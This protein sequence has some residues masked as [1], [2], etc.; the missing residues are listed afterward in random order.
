M[1]DD[2]Q[3]E[4]R[5]L[6][7]SI[8]A[9][10]GVQKV[11]L[12]LRGGTLV[13]VLSGEMYETDVAI[14]DG[15]VV[16]LGEGYEGREVVDCSGKW[17]APGF[18]DGHMHVES[19]LVTV[20]EFA[21][22]ALSRGTVAAILDPHEI[23]NVHGIE[24][25]LYILES[26]KGIPLKAF[27]MASSCVPA[28]HME[29]A[30]AELSA[31]DLVPLFDEE[32]VIG[33]AEVMNFP[34]VVFGDE[35]VLAKVVAAQRDNVVID[36]HA[37]GLSGRDLN[38]YIAAGVGSDHECTTLEEAREKLRKGMHVMIREASTAKN[39]ETLLPLVTPANE[40]RCCFVTDDRHPSDLLTEGH[41]DHAV[42][43]AIRLGLD[44]LIA[45]RMASLNT[46][47]WFRLD[48]QGFG[49][50]A[51]GFRA[52]VLVLDDLE[53]VRIERVYVGGELVA[54]DGEVLIDLPDAPSTL[55]S[56]VN[57]NWERFPGF[58]IPAEGERVKVI[59]IIPGQIVTGRGVDEARIENG[60][61]VADPVRDLLKMAVVERHG[62][63]SGVGLALVR[64]FGLKDGA[65]ASSVAHDSHNVVIAGVNDD[66]MRRALEAIVEMDGGLV[67]VQGGEVHAA[68]ALPI[69]GLMSDRPLHEV[70][71]A[72][73]A[74]H[75]AY[76]RLGGELSDPFMQLSFL[77]LPVIPTLKLTDK[78]VVDVEKFEIVSLWEG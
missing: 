43:K 40:R 37:P 16:G 73:D 29:T 23:A 75:D 31:E 42:R 71:N 62:K 4:I 45:Y 48:E 30:G 11:D 3:A 5:T 57:V 61:V 50:V 63:G 67:V 19:T 44:S 33:L 55:P 35:G 66:D 60:E 25:I 65:I 74:L 12:L 36:G 14:H 47:E 10:R 70:R 58:R 77:A 27:V 41:V 26:R 28:T 13:N 46:A 1:K 7:S 15:W 54:Q 51:P 72:V 38:A 21:R 49:A 20:P 56:S 69:A 78:G 53:A 76:H 34:G 9:A 22:A 32:G 59:E 8:E 18:I 24:G 39:L 6:Q 52:D 64:G 17:I 2:L 68:L